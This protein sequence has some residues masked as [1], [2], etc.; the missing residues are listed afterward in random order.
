MVVERWIS[1]D[2]PDEWRSALNGI[3]HTFGHTWESGRATGVYSG[4]LTYLYE[5]ETD[6][7]RLVCPIQERIFGDATDIVTPHGFSGFVGEGD[8]RAVAA[9]WK[10]SATER[11][12][13]CGYLVTNPALKNSLVL[14]PEDTF[15]K[16]HI[17]VFDLTRAGRELHARLSSNRQRELKRWEEVAE[18]VV[19][20]KSRLTRFFLDNFREFFA[21]RKA[22]ST[23]G[24]SAGSV[25]LLADADTVL[26]AGVEDNGALTA[27]SMFA[28]TPSGADYLFNISTPSG[29]RHSAVL[30]WWAVERF[31]TM[32]IPHLNLGGG[33]VE[34]DGIA[35]FKARFGAEEVALPVVKE[36]YNSARYAE[37]CRQVGADHHDMRGYFPAYRDA[38]RLPPPPLGQEVAV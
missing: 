33:L 2:S 37:L 36:V 9:H 24:L 32:Q 27:A 15:H 22:V 11:E 23:H 10:R 20:D 18:T 8:C 34:G 38:R 30:I 25:Q 35:L 12:Y 29:R 13:V 6:S 31:K 16:K 28:Y 19:I 5:L 26:M 3:P 17:Y 7:G 4:C 14:S 21:R 1:V